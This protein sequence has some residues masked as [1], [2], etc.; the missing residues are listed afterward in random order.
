M[1]LICP[2]FVPGDRPDRFA[3]AA[4][5]GTDGV[6]I[7]LEDA[8]A[9]SA[10][11]HAREIIE[12][13]FGP[14]PVDSTTSVATDRERYGVSVGVRVNPATTENG[15][16]DAELL[17]SFHYPPDFVVAP[18]VE[19]NDDIDRLETYY[20]T[21]RERPA[22]MPPLF[23][24]IETAKGVLNTREICGDPRVNIVGV[25]EADLAADVRL[26][27]SSDTGLDVSRSLVCLASAEANKQPPLGSPHFEIND[28]AGLRES[29]SY[30]TQ[31]GFGGRACIHPEQ[32]APVREAFLPSADDVQWARRVLRAF[33]DAEDS[34]VSSIKLRDGTF[35]DYPIATR[36]RKMMDLAE[37]FSYGAGQ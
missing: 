12:K 29:S 36:A 35:V 20:L 11:S 33:R 34:G 30:L 10:K 31:M 1:Q 26:S 4:S 13:Y 7:D 21:G 32:I 24:L 23:V 9:T 28:E 37:R 27:P 8:V 25:G 22:P 14:Q 19:S 16:C 17:Q 6:I 2:L 3:K 5:S 15:K 18:M